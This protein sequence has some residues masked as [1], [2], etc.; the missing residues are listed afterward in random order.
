MR[1]LGLGAL[2]CLGSGCLGAKAGYALY[3]L[4]AAYSAAEQENASELATYEHTLAT[5]YRAKAWEEA[6]YNRYEASET[7]VAKA[8]GYSNQA[9]SAAAQEAE[10]LRVL[11]EMQQD[12]TLVPEQ[13]PV[14]PD[15]IELEDETGEPAADPEPAPDSEPVWEAEQTEEP[16]LDEWVE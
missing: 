13:V 14:D 9:A 16:L 12:E 10:A 6:G 8:T 2:V 5:A 11:E 3:E 1:G 15:A 4:E 7:L